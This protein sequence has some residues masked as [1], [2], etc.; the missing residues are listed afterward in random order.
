MHFTLQSSDYDSSDDKQSLADSPITQPSPHS[1]MGDDKSN[2]LLND[3][4]S[5]PSSI[6]PETDN[7]VVREADMSLTEE[8]RDMKLALPR[9]INNY[10]Y[11]LLSSQPEYGINGTPPHDND[12]T[13]QFDYPQNVK[14]DFNWSDT[15]GVTP[16]R[17]ARSSSSAVISTSSAAMN[18]TPV[19]SGGNIN[20]LTPLRLRLGR[21]GVEQ[22]LQSDSNSVFYMESSQEEPYEEEGGLMIDESPRRSR[23]R[24][25]QAALVGDIGMVY[26]GSTVDVAGE[27]EVAQ[28]QQNAGMNGIDELLRASAYAPA[29]EFS[30]NAAPGYQYRPME[31]MEGSGR[32]SPSTRDAIAGMLSMSRD[33]SGGNNEEILGIAVSGR[34]RL[35][36][37]AVSA[38]Q[39]RTP[40]TVLNKQSTRKYLEEDSMK[41]V[42]QDEDY[43]YPTL[44]HSDDEDYPVFK[45][46]GKKKEDEAWNPKARVRVWGPKPDRPARLGVKRQSVEKGLEV[47]ANRRNTQ[48]AAKRAY[49]R[50]KTNGRGMMPLGVMEG[51]S[52]LP[53]VSGPSGPSSVAP[54]VTHHTVHHHTGHR[55][56]KGM[57]TAKQRLGKILKI[58]KMIY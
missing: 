30:N 23:G 37:A 35:Q 15:P 52:G 51:P 44:D 5:T 11:N 27:V 24:V 8:E 42:H 38:G 25:R 46:R 18:G 20:R 49:H 54:T 41:K 22:G 10:P 53:G 2:L 9:P 39:R 43:V 48:P 12:Y 57:A 47:A 19:Q 58:H 56:K 4:H 33:V 13:N 26:G 45:P 36:Y 34:H 6:L 31:E 40:A 29:T 7:H 50:K 14:S 32:T 17:L 21:Q 1:I 16:Y 28:P 55:P 3:N